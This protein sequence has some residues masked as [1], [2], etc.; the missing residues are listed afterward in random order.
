MTSRVNRFAIWLA[1]VLAPL[2]LDGGLSLALAQA[3]L[4]ATYSATLFGLPIGHIS[5]TVEL[6][7]NRFT[8]AATGGISG[9]L[10]IF[11]DGH[12]DVSAQGNLS[13]GEPIASHFALT[14]I[15]GKW[16]DDVRIQFR[17]NKAQE[18]VTALPAPGANQVPITDANRTGVLD[19][20]TALL[21]PIPG[22]GKT[23]VP[24]ACERTI[25]IFD[26]HTRYNLRL[27][28]KRVDTV[29]N[30]G[31]YQGP[32][33]V[34]AVKFFPVAGYDP[35][36]FLVTYLAAQRD[37]EIWLAPIAGSRLMVPYRMSM[38]TPMGLGILQATKFESVP[39]KSL[40][41]NLN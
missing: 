12:G 6:R 7:N 34:C 31:V 39:A 40:T 13:G 25:P 26:G 38:P 9:L 35:K 37:I 16:S 27:S 32:V 23:A 29:N 33:I 28:F 21:V 8:S 19:P 10:R 20:M 41:T 5:W 18:Y 11:S 15:A 24:E 2:L 3:K 14:L 30:E 17:G 36:H 22:A 1:S 4:D